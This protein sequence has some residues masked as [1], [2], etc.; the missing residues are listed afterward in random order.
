M[1]IFQNTKNNQ[2]LDK[3]NTELQLEVQK[4]MSCNYVGLHLLKYN[5]I[6]WVKATTP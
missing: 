6:T 2:C 4:R 3:L 1:K 5:L